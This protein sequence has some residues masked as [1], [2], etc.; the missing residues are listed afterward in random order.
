M[1]T[2][3]TESSGGTAYLAHDDDTECAELAWSLDATP[4]ERSS[5]DAT[6]PVRQSWAVVCCFAAALLA[7]GAA[8]AV[9]VVIEMPRSASTQARGVGLGETPAVMQPS[10][11]P[12]SALPGAMPS[13]PELAEHEIPPPTLPATGQPAPTMAVPDQD[14]AYLAALRESG[15]VITDPAQAVSGGRSVCGYLRQGHSQAEAVALG[16]RENPGLSPM[17]AIHAVTDAVLAF[18]PEMNRR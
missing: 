16:M 12:A 13:S 17:D 10:A 4:D 9:A 3:A 6:T 7:A 5:D 15:I 8:A 11:E 2:A 18:C 1:V 14:A